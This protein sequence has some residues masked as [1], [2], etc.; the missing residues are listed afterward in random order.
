MEENAIENVVWKKGGH[1][2]SASTCYWPR[3]EILS[4]S[5]AT[6]PFLPS[7]TLVSCCYDTDVKTGILECIPYGFQ[8]WFTNSDTW[9]PVCQTHVSREGP[10]SYVPYIIYLWDLITC[11]QSLIAA[12]GTHTLIFQILPISQSL[13][14]QHGAHLGPV[15][16]RWAPC[17]PHEPC[18]LGKYVPHNKRLTLSHISKILATIIDPVH[19]IVYETNNLLIFWV[20]WWLNDG[21]LHWNHSS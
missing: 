20:I 4:A 8:V 17:W 18:Y 13:W 10:S 15:C 1:L 12:S 11:F 5:V 3:L 2:V 14:D 21:M 16:P 6:S 7:D 9:V 19:C